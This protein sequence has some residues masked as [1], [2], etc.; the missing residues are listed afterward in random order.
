MGAWC[1][2]ICVSVLC[3]ATAVHGLCSELYANFTPHHRQDSYW[4]LCSKVIGE[5]RRNEF[6]ERIINTTLLYHY[7]V[8]HGRDGVD[9]LQRINVTEV[10]LLVNLFQNR[11]PGI[12]KSLQGDLKE[13]FETIQ[14]TN[15]ALKTT[16]KLPPVAS[17]VQRSLITFNAN[18]GHSYSKRYLFVSITLPNKNK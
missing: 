12:A 1:V 3:C 8:S 4:D 9:V 16:L 6:L 18:S 2:F 17:G 10:S 15:G 13:V 5:T 7:D 14:Y 11:A